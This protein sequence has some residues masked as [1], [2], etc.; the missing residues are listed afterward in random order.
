MAKFENMNHY[1]FLNTDNILVDTNIWLRLFGPESIA[2]PD[3]YDEPF[4]NMRDQ[5]TK[6][7]INS[8]IISEFIN[9][10]LRSSYHA[11]LK[12]LGFTS[13]EYD[14]K[15]H[16]RPSDD[17]KKRYKIVM[18][19]LHQEILPHVELLSTSQNT[20]I[21]SIEECK[22]YMH[23][24][25]ID[26]NDELIIHDALNN[27]CKILTADKD[28]QHFPGNELIIITKQAI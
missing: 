7:F 23:R 1:H 13:Y 24:D 21:S 11:K 12:A 2:I 25:F 22:Q 27:D 4:F 8:A 16:Y 15:E 18:E 3:G 9:T 28:Y 17:F 5:G 20:L 19:T 6:M 26:F 14:Y 10:S